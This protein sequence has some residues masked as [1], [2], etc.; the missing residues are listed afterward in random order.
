MELCGGTHV[1]ALGT[2]GPFRIVQESSIGANTRRIEATTG[3]GSLAEIRKLTVAV[4]RASAILHSAPDELAEAVGRLVERE[5]GLAEELRRRQSQALAAEA[6]ELAAAAVSG[7]VVARRDGIDPAGLREL[8]LATRRAGGVDAVGLVGATTD[9]RVGIVVAVAAAS[10]VD[11]R[12][13]ASA[14]AAKVGGGGGGSPEFATA[15]GRDVTSVDE[16]LATLGALLG[17]R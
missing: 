17:S 16:A 1:S 2:I 15:G 4:N 10:G 6:R 12:A 5:R 11:A 13:V 7:T 8:A 9:G 3:T 14:A